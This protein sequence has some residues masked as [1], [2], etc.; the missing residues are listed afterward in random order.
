VIVRRGHADVEV[1]VKNIVDN[2][3]STASAALIVVLFAGL[4]FT[5]LTVA[6][7]D[8]TGAVRQHLEQIVDVR[9]VRAEPDQVSGVLV[10][11]SSKPVRNVRVRIDRSWLWA[12]ERHAGGAEES[13]GR[14]AVYTVPGEIPPGG[15]LPF[16]YRS[17]TPLPQRSDGRF[18]TSVSVVGLE[19]VG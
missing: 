12:D 9:D 18:E 7:E 4:G 1:S 2:V 11:L 8:T 17:D 16:T 6:A 3:A 19:Q 14:T 5:S 10:N 15:H 13:P